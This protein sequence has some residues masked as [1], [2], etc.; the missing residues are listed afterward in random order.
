[1]AMVED[2][3]PVTHQSSTSSS[4]RDVHE[5]QIGKFNDIFF[6]SLK[7][8]QILNVNDSIRWRSEREGRAKSNVQ[9][10]K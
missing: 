1:M 4:S 7:K 5:Q 3:A 6:N 2:G 10:L 8:I 9:L